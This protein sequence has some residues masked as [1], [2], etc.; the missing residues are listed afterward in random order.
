MTS[1]KPNSLVKSPS[2]NTIIVEVRALAYGW[3]STNLQSLIASELY[4]GHSACL[5]TLKKSQKVIRLGP[6]KS[7]PRIRNCYKHLPRPRPGLVEELAL[8][9]VPGISLAP[10]E[11]LSLSRLVTGGFL[12][13]LPRAWNGCYL[14]GPGFCG[15]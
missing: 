12:I 13:H 14:R 6:H 5:T 8:A 2:S 11:E 9:L 15:S 3:S 4:Q 7:R 1:S 10:G